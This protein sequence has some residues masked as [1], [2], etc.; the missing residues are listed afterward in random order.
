MLGTA[1]GTSSAYISSYGG[2]GAATYAQTWWNKTNN[3]DYPYY[4]EYYGQST[5]TNNL[6]DLP[7]GASGQSN[8]RRGWN[9]CTNFISQAIYEGG[10]EMIQSG[11]LLPHQNVDNWYYTDSKPSHTWGGA[12]NFYQHFSARAGVASSSGLLQVGDAISV[13]FTGDGSC[14]H[15]IIITYATGTYTNQQYVTYHTTDSKET[16]TLSYFYDTANYPNRILYGYELDL[17]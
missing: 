2:S 15:T 12:P 1:L 11:W 9:D 3:T 17:L 13:D 8:P 7:S 16:R 10:V 5:S 14:D 6:N 4:A